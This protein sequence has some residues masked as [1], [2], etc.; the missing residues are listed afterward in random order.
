MQ[1]LAA[2][3]DAADPAPRKRAAAPS[4]FADLQTPSRSLPSLPNYFQVKLPVHLRIV[5]TSAKM[6][7]KSTRKKDARNSQRLHK[8]Q[9]CKQLLGRGLDLS[10]LQQQISAGADSTLTC[11]R[12]LS[13]RSGTSPTAF[14]LV[15]WE[16]GQYGIGTGRTRHPEHQRNLGGEYWTSKFGLEPEFGFSRP[17]NSSPTIFAR[18]SRPCVCMSKTQKHEGVGTSTTRKPAEGLRL[19]VKKRKNTGKRKACLGRACVTNNF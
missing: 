18:F 7:S 17:R 15:S 8:P 4:I 1:V 2:A 14:E 12:N 5:A 19:Y 13:V 6:A 16:M 9:A 3:E 11:H 10:Q